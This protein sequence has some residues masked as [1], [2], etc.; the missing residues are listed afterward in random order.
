MKFLIDESVEYRLVIFLR[1]ADYDTSSIAELSSGSDDET[2]LSTAYKENR[3]L[4]TNDKDFGELIYKL[5]LPH[6]GIILFRLIEESYQSKINK[7]EHILKKF[8]EKLSN[9]YT[10]VS[11]TKIRFRT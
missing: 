5:S 11:D 7:L 10:T 8:K 3:I 2:V 1:D 9:N 4:I 6:K